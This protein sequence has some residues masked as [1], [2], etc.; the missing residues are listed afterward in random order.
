[1]RQRCAPFAPRVTCRQL[2]PSAVLL[3]PAC[4]EDVAPGAGFKLHAGPRRSFLLPLIAP[5]LQKQHLCAEG[6]LSHSHP[7]RAGEILLGGGRGAWSP[8]QIQGRGVAKRGSEAY[9]LNTN[10]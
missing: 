7:P 5:I 1:M 8:P 9:F 6:Q 4:V 2:R 10:V 3:R